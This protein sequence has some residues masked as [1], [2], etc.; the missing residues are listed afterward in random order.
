MPRYIKGL[1][2]ANR[3]YAMQALTREPSDQ[4]IRLARKRA[5][6][7]AATLCTSVQR[8]IDEPNLDKRAFVALNE[9]LAANYLLAS[10]LA[11]MRVLFRRRGAELEP[12]STEELLAQSRQMVTAAFALGGDPKAAPNTLSRPSLEQQL[13]SPSAVYSLRR[14]LIHIDRASERVAALA[15]RALKEAA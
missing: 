2:I 7:M 15:A 12:V 10:D 9:L 3:D 13:E 6:D 4:A 11:S 14:R 1:M 5:H 8:L